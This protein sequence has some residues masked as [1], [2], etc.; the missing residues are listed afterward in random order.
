[1]EH[2]DL[3]CAHHNQTLLYNLFDVAQS[4]QAPICVIGITSRTDVIELLEKRVKSRFSHRQYSLNPEE[5]DFET[6]MNLFEKL[7]TISYADMKSGCEFKIADDC[8]GIWNESIKNLAKSNE[9]RQN[10]EQRY[11]I[12]ILIA[13]FKIFLYQ[14]ISKLSE[15]HP[16]LIP[17]DFSELVENLRMDNKIPILCGLSVM[18]L[19]LVVAMKHHCQIYDRDHFNFEMILTRFNKFAATTSTL[20]NISRDVVHKAFER[21]L[22]L[23][24]IIPE[25]SSGINNTLKQFRFY[26]L[27]LTFAQIDAAVSKYTGLPT[28]ISQWAITSPV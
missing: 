23:E 8:I 6:R 16:F 25:S 1:M 12:C 27:I 11:D 21:I 13:S 5:H 22:Q 14:V 2:F 18:E 17:Q 3:F 26:Y 9:I 7:L 19:C 15:S 20:Q 28:D 10:L 24:L 4:A